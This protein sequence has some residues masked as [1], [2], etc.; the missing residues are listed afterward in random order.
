MFL[1]A[2]VNNGRKG[3]FFMI[4]Q[5]KPMKRYRSQG[6]ILLIPTREIKAAD[7]N[8][9]LG[10]TTLYHLVSEGVIPSVPVGKKKLIDLDRLEEYLMGG[11]ADEVCS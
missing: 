1:P 6:R 3:R 2:C 4:W 10:L 7:P 9:G 8:S 11:P 5:N